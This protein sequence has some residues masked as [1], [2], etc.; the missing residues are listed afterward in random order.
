MAL[1]LVLVLALLLRLVNINQSFWLDESVQALTSNGSFL[2]LLHELKGDFHPPLYHFL[3]WGW[4]RLFGN[5][6]IAMRMPSVLLGVATVWLTYLIAKQLLDKQA[7]KDK[8][9]KWLPLVSA[10]F[11]ATA[12]F[13]IYYSQEA[14]MY[15]AGAFFTALSFYFFLRL[16]NRGKNG[17]DW[18]A[19]F[20]ILSTLGML[21]CDYYGLFAFFVQIIASVFFLR[22]RTMEFARNFGLISVLFLPALI[23]LSI[24]L[25][26]GIAAN[27]VLPGWGQLVNLNFFKALPLTFIK[28]SLG[29]ITIFNKQLYAFVGVTLF[30]IYALVMGQSLL[31]K[32][33]KLTV[34]YQSLII[35]FLW[36]MAPVFLAWIVSFLIP[37]YQPFRLLLS[38]TPFYIL[39]SIGAFRIEKLFLRWLIIGFVVVVNLTALSVYYFNPYF[40]REDWRGATRY[41]EMSD[42]QSLVVFPS[43]TSYWPYYYYSEGKVPFVGAG[44]GIAQVTTF[45]T[46]NLVKEIPNFDRLEKVYYIYYLADL[47]DPNSLVINWLEGH[48][49]V[50]IGETIFNQLRIQEWQ[51]WK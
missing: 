8:W 3:M 39:L 48:N 11:M 35:I 49:F 15:A 12:P 10:V 40:H 6:E 22:K 47:F 51:R 36:F 25:K 23:L 24:Q 28:F 19:V 5:S 4:A 18:L 20:Y 41:I 17:L 7:L 38:L 37:N 21:Y 29:R 45:N 2:G 27:E 31:I 43:H 44:K 16:V 33:K 13:H 30:V 9:T 26:T 14:R 1:I 32:K 46:A 42:K 50:K 34:N